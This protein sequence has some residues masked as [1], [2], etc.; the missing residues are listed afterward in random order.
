MATTRE[1]PP[2]QQRNDALRRHRLSRYE[3]LGHAEKI[4]LALQLLGDVSEH[5][6]R[7]DPR[8]YPEEL[9]S[10]D[11]YLCEIGCKLG[12]IEWAGD[13]SPSDSP[14]LRPEWCDCSRVQDDSTYAPDG[15]CSCGELKHHWHCDS[16]GGLVQ[17]G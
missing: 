6:E 10:F 14:K 11:E 3:T 7:E 17:V 13:G 8:H 2:A 12:A 4:R 9:P 1:T 15:W 5:W 16:C